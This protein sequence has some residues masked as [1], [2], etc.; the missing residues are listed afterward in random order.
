[1][2]HDE[3][4]KEISFHTVCTE[5]TK[6]GMVCD[7]EHLREFYPE[8]FALRAVVELHRPYESTNAGLICEFCVENDSRDH[9]YPC[10]TIQAIEKEII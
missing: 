6:P 9:R 3:L 8:W 10:L 1:M 7:N 2:T 5:P 4:L